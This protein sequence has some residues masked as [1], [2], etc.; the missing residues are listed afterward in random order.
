MEIAIEQLKTFSTDITQVLNGL[1][2]QLN[3]GSLMLQNI[4]KD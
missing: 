3:P 1:L 4:K 2:M